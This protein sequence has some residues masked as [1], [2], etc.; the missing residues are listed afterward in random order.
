VL[1]TTR[2][3]LLDLEPWEGRGA[4]T[5]TL[6]GLPAVEQ[7]A[8]L[9]AWGVRAPDAELDRVLE[10]FGGHALSVATLGSLV[11]GAYGGDLS[12]LGPLD[13]HDAREDDP[14]AHRL[15]GLLDAYADALTDAQADLLARVAVFPQGVG[16][17][18]LCDLAEDAALGGSMP[19]SRRTLVQTL[20]RLEAR[21]LVH[22]S[23]A[24]SSR[25]GVHPSH[26]SH[27]R[28]RLGVGATAIHDVRRRQLQARL[29]DPPRAMPR[30]DQLD[31]LEELLTHTRLAGHA[32]EAFAL[33]RRGL[34]GFDGLGLER[35]DMAR[36]AR[37]LR[38]F[39]HDDDPALPM[40]GLAPWQVQAVLYEQALFGCALGDPSFALACLERFVA[41]T[42]AEPRMH[43]TGLRTTAYVLRLMGRFDD[44]LSFVRRAL[45]AAPGE[46]DHRVRNLALEGA[47]HHDCGAFDDAARCFAE[48]R[49]LDPQPRFRRALW[50]AEHRLECGDIEG[51][52][53]LAEAT[54]RAC[55]VRGWPGHVSHADVVVGRCAAARDPDVAG[56]A[57]TEALRWAERSGEVEA[58]LR[59]YEL[60]LLLVG[61]PAREQL[62]RDAQS[63]ANSASFGRFT[64]R[65]L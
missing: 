4:R 5:L 59:C 60:Q 31:L 27:F 1:I 64:G 39:L 24:A 45:S 26:G 43:T 37:I 61:D 65:F 55:E 22:R 3:P 23:H 48:A 50:E 41:L 42:E 57:H 20:S 15:A 19:Q 29:H 33:Y 35:G 54:R 28:E 34:G 56:R 16:I 52:S 12:L 47:V 11:M 51:A 44:A 53:Q 63:L 36:G 2:I 18:T 62:R 25:F 32:G 8:L 46:D 49:T 17:E 6:S 13:L 21:G 9:R 30:D 7:R 58:R 10:R 40:P 14:L 38:G